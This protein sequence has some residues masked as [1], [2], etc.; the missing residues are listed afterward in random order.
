MSDEWNGVSMT[1]EGFVEPVWSPAVTRTISP[2]RRWA[3]A[4]LP[5]R[6]PTLLYTAMA[7][8]MS[9]CTS[10]ETPTEPSAGTSSEMAATKTYTAV[11]L[12]TLGGN[13]NY[14]TA[15][16]AAG[17][18]VG[19]S[20]LPGGDTH[21]FLWEKGVMTDLGTLGGRYSDAFGINE[22][23]QVVGASETAE[24]DNHAFLWE[25]GVMTDLGTIGERSSAALDI[26]ARGQ[27][28]GGADGI[29]VRWEKGVMVSLPLPVGGTYCAVQEINAAGRG[30]GQCTVGNT[31]RAVLWERGRV[32]DLGTLGGTLATATG[33]NARGAVVGISWVLFGN[34]VHPFLWER[35]TMSDLSTQG[36]PEGFIP[37]AI[38]AGG[39]IAGHY[40]G[41]GQVHAAV[42]QRGRMIDL[43]SPGIDNY[44]SDINASG[45]VV[46]Y[47]VGGDGYHAVLWTRK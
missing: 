39:Q 4:A 36:A 7:L 17:A 8:A 16:N 35:G 18:V 22:R 44:V 32:T 31:A 47:T 40:G 19:G 27:I 11:D 10:E 23:G 21:A 46:G 34:G 43:S 29:P 45:Q 1:Q 20:T 37:N 42:W 28:V 26:N 24:G 41:G 9:G 5:V 30:V 12:G 38:N 25:K 6:L 13:R 33:I 3:R 15:I 14:A 2:A